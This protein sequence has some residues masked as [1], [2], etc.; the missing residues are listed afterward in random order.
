MNL[1]FTESVS[2]SSKVAV[3]IDIGGTHVKVGLV[4]EHGKILDF[5]SYLLVRD[6]SHKADLLFICQT[7]KSFINK[8]RLNSQIIGV[9]IACP[10]ILDTEN[11]VVIHA[12][13]LAW[14]H[15]PLVDVMEKF[16][17]VNCHLISDAAASALGERYGI[18]GN[19]SD[20][21]M[22]CIGTGLGAGLIKNYQLAQVS[23]GGVINLGHMSVVPNGVSC[24]CGNQGCLEKY[25]S[26]TAII[27]KVT[28][29]LKKNE[30]LR[31][32]VSGSSKEL[33]PRI[34]FEAAKSGDSY[35]RSVFQEAGRLLGIAI[36]NCMHLFN[37]HHFIIGGGV[38]QAGAYLLDPARQEASARV[39]QDSL[40]ILQSTMPTEAGVRGVAH[41]VFRW[42]KN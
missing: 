6:N 41:E 36:V 16:I 20:F 25:V 22:I 29:D 2:D 14:A 27:E 28:K 35:A 10:G 4:S 32:N 24:K 9:G 21:M 30:K 7:V 13:N 15:V 3:G 11:G 1:P 39:N 40:K 38:S 12:V 42:R 37:V 19:V 31:R 26:A 18:A 23:A 17:H 8:H 5:Q 33:Y 34:L